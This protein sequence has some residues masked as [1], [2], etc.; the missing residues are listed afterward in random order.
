M[1]FGSTREASQEN[2]T[3]AENDEGWYLR[4]ALTAF[5]RDPQKGL[6]KKMGWPMQEVRGDTLIALGLN[7]T[8]VADEDAK[9]IDA[10]CKTKLSEYFSCLFK[11]ND[12]N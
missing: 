11:G 7:D 5:A 10:D 4:E 1:L 2:V 6:R 9:A 12:A 3:K 8:L